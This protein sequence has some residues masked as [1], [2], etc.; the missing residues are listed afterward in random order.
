MKKSKGF[1]NR[2]VAFM[3]LMVFGM[4]VYGNTLLQDYKYAQDQQRIKSYAETVK[5]K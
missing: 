4:C 1:N 5:N 2:A 3:A